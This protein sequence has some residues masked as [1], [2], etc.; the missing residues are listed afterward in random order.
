MNWFR[1]KTRS[2]PDL[3]NY[4]TSL[5]KKDK[6]IFENFLIHDN[7]PLEFKGDVK[8]SGVLKD[9]T[10]IERKLIQKEENSRLVDYTQYT[11]KE[12]IYAILKPSYD[13]FNKI[14]NHE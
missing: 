14:K 10:M 5:N 7:E 13:T 12:E 1:K 11:I 8:Q 4:M 6:Q 3:W 2:I 9:K